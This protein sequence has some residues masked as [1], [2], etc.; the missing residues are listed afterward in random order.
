VPFTVPTWPLLVL[1]HVEHHF[2]IAT[3]WTALS[4]K[5]WGSCMYTTTM[6][7][8]QKY[9]AT[10]S[11]HAAVRTDPSDRTPCQA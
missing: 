9:V 11:Q 10:V 3:P 8:I 4:C 1:Q 5:S 6:E 7:D 2:D